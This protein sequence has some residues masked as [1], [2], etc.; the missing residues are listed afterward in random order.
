VAAAVLGAVVV[1][2]LDGLLVVAHWGAMVFPIFF[3]IYFLDTAS[4]KNIPEALWP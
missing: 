4:D 1:A 2:I 3:L